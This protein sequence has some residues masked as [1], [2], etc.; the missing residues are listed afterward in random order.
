MSVLGAFVTA[1]I[2]FVALSFIGHSQMKKQM[3]RR[4]QDTITR[5]KKAEKEVDQLHEQKNELEED[6]ALT[7]NELEQT[8]KKVVEA[9]MVIKTLFPDTFKFRTIDLLRGQGFVTEE[10]IKAANAYILESST[11]ES[12]EKILVKRGSLDLIRLEKIDKAAE[13]MNKLVG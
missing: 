1:F 12:L 6:L 5:M 3:E 8:Q 13:I 7:K 4:M 9:S 2:L 10:D 11:D